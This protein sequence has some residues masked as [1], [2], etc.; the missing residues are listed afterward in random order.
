MKLNGRLA[1]HC[2]GKKVRDN[3]TAVMKLNCRLAV[4]CVGKKVRDNLTAVMKLAVHCLGKRQ[5]G[6]A[7]EIEPSSSSSLCRQE[8]NFTA[9]IRLKSSPT[10]CP[11]CRR[12]T[13]KP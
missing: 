3:L 13:R 1:V 2:A 4:H 10:N 5:P 6:S 7:Y 11:V 8:T 12:E 9:M